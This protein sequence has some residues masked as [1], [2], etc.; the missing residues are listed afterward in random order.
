MASTVAMGSLELMRGSSTRNANRK[1]E[2][3]EQSESLPTYGAIPPHYGNLE[4]VCFYGRVDASR[5]GT[6]TFR[7]L[8]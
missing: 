4:F 5:L 3:K 7:Y 2:R 6:C 1:D 8:T